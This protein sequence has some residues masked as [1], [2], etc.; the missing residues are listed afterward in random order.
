MTNTSRKER[1]MSTNGTVLEQTV[2]QVTVIKRT[3]ALHSGSGILQKI[4]RE[5]LFDSKVSA[6]GEEAQKQVA[7]DAIRSSMKPDEK[8]NHDELEV[9]C[10]PF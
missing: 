2:A 4:N 8:L 10:R 3:E 9:T 5:I 7:Y 1:D 6:V